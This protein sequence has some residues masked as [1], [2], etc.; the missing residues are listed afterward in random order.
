MG[1]KEL[2]MGFSAMSMTPSQM[3]NNIKVCR[4][5]LLKEGTLTIKARARR[6]HH[7]QVD[8]DSHQD[9]HSLDLSPTRF[10]SPPNPNAL[11]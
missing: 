10:V 4:I 6:C 9:I 5:Y 8:C 2:K 1:A 7:L 3:V 11:S